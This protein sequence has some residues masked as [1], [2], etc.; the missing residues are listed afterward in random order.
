M[1]GVGFPGHFLVRYEPG[2][3]E[4]QWLDVFDGA[5]P[6][7]RDDLA[8]RL[9]D[10]AGEEL[11]DEHLAVVGTRAIL[12]RMLNNLLNLAGREDEPADM[13]RYLDAMLVVAPDSARDRV[14]RMV[15]SYRLGR[16]DVALADARWLLEHAPEGIDLDQVRRMAEMLESGAAPPPALQRPTR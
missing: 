5:K 7:S 9:R 8:E 13:L 4:P 3:G 16:R 10:D 14:M 11:A 12:S 2:E 15:T 6:L 1:Q